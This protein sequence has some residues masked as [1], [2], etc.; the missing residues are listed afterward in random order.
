MSL[1]TDQPTSFTVGDL[2]PP[3]A[4]VLEDGVPGQLR[5]VDLTTAEAI[6]VHIIRP[7]KSVVVLA[8]TIVDAEAGTW[9]AP[10]QDGNLNL[11]GRYLVEVQVLWPGGRPQTFGRVAFYVRREYA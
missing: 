11:P 5:P 8:A 9:I 2:E 3:L 1:T 4:G 6:S 10:W 7:D